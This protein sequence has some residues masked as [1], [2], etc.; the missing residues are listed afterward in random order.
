TDLVGRR[1]VYPTNPLGDLLPDDG[2]A[3]HEGDR[4]WLTKVPV[5][6]WQRLR[7]G[8]PTHYPVDLPFT[9]SDGPWR[10][11]HGVP[12]G[13]SRTPQ[14]AALAAIWAA[15]FLVFPH[16]GAVNMLHAYGSIEQQ[17]ILDDFTPNEEQKEAAAAYDGTS[18][19]LIPRAY[20]IMHYDG[21]HAL[22]QLATG[23]RNTMKVV[24]MS[25]TWDDTQKTWHGS[26]NEFFAD[27]GKVT[28]SE[29]GEWVRL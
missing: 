3:L 1:V 14:G 12:A 11:I 29:L 21:N 9:A 6:E 5:I 16:D 4:G 19:F 17:K 13:Y 2:T 22:V 15:N 20:R 25:L 10:M 23:R 8:D 27:A 7:E 24:E 18:V 26:S 28:T